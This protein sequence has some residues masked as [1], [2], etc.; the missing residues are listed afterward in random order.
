MNDWQKGSGSLKTLPREL[1]QGDRRQS[2]EHD[3]IVNGLDNRMGG[4]NPATTATVLD[5]T[6]VL[7]LRTRVMQDLA[8]L[9]NY[10]KEKGKGRRPKSGQ[11]SNRN[12]NGNIN[13]NS[14]GNS[15]ADLRICLKSTIAPKIQTKPNH[16]TDRARPIDRSRT[17]ETLP[18]RYQ[19]DQRGG[20][21]MPRLRA[22]KGV[23]AC[24]IIPQISSIYFVQI[25]RFD[26]ANP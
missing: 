21:P 22:A 2:Q 20:V 26:K 11:S 5:R 12:S 24:A 3:E 16:A 23:I 14:S 17:G 13:G 7:L 1:M 15:N 9:K 10:R 4:V 18:V 8:T 19:G 6:A 25:L